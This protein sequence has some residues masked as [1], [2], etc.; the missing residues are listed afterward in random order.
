MQIDRHDFLLNIFMFDKRGFR[1][2]KLSFM[3]E[4]IAHSEY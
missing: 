3:S 2:F 4:I 1:K